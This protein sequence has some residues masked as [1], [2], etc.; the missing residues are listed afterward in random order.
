LGFREPEVCRA[1]ALLEAK[2]DIQASSIDTLRREALLASPPLEAGKLAGVEPKA[3]LRTAV[4]AALP[5]LRNESCLIPYEIT[6]ASEP[7]CA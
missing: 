1:L 2:L 6:T 4:F 7:P 5:Q 3:H